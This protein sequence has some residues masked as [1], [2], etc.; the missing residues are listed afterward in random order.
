MTKHSRIGSLARL[1]AA[2][3]FALPLHAQAALFLDGPATVMP[4]QTFPLGIGLDS[5][6]LADID[7]LMLTVQF[8]PAVLAGQN[9]AAGALLGSGSFLA[10]AATGVATHSFPMTLAQLGPGALATWTLAVDPAAV[11]NSVTIVR[12]TLETSVID[13]DPTA[14]LS[15]GPLTI[16]VVPE[17]S[18]AALLLAGLALVGGLAAVRRG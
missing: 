10:N 4:G 14:T 16:T 13:S 18:S 9:A 8:D 15:A 6:L 7:N 1:A 3:A 17:P 2:F 12:A 5:A 11:P